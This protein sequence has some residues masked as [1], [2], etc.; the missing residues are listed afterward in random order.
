MD[1]DVSQNQPIGRVGPVNHAVSRFTSIGR[2]HRSGPP[3][4]H[5]PVKT[6]DSGDRMGGSRRMR[7]VAPLKS[8]WMFTSSELRKYT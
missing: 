1:S 8:W 4:C 5:E 3:R 6:G 7:R 2:V